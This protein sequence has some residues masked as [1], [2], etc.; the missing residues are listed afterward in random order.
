ML[1]NSAEIPGAVYG[2]G[3]IMSRGRTL[4]PASKADMET[5]RSRRGG[6]WPATVAEAVVEESVDPELSG[7]PRGSGVDMRGLVLGELL[8]AWAWPWPC[9]DELSAR[10]RGSGVDIRGFVLGEAFGACAAVVV[11]L[12]HDATVLAVPGGDLLGAAWGCCCWAAAP[13]LWWLCT[14]PP[15]PWPWLG[16]MVGPGCCWVG[17]AVG[18]PVGT[19]LEAPVVG[20]VGIV[21]IPGWRSASME[22]APRAAAD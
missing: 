18:L 22:R 16:G 15:W 5:M 19:R 9:P 10:P 21:G 6:R 7:R 8:G 3:G 17:E 1:G 2:A 20:I 13:L 12:R 14:C 4:Q 11:G